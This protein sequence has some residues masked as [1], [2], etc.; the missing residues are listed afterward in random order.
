MAPASA[1]A[2]S[3]DALCGSPTLAVSQLAALTHCPPFLRC[4]LP[5]SAMSQGQGV[6]WKENED[7]SPMTNVGDDGGGEGTRCAQTLPAFSPVPVARLGH[8]T[9]PREP[10]ERTGYEDGCLMIDVGKMEDENRK[11]GGYL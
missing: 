4:R 11:D 3:S 8:A 7:G 6:L 10:Y 2:N 9:R 1:G 5:G